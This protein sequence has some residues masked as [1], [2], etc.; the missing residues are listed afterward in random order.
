MIMLSVVT[1]YP[2][3]SSW[4]TVGGSMKIISVFP[5]LVSVRTDALPEWI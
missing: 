5:V 1:G 2:D 3:S 4:G